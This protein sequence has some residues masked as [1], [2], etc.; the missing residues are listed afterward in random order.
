M[1]ILLTLGLVCLL[2]GCS[3]R[4]ES[5]T[6]V[7]AG[8]SSAETVRSQKASG[9]SAPET[10]TPQAAAVG[11]SSE[12]SE[13]SA[14]ELTETEKIEALIHHIESLSDAVFVR[15]NA[16][17]DCAGAAKHMRDKWNWKKKEIHTAGDFIRVAATK[18]S[19]SGEVYR[20]RFKDG[21]DVACGEYLEAQLKTIE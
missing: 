1:R 3:G 6:T 12:S 15:N 10:P 8:S 9:P 2:S 19:T 13:A 21:R 16:E 5:P 14:R 4:S 17:H 20:I 7:P 11:S 18:S